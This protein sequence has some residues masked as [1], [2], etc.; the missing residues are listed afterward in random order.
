M[1]SNAYPAQGSN[2]SLISE[3][4]CRGYWKGHEVAVKTILFQDTGGSERGKLD[5]ACKE[6]AIA[7]KLCHPSIVRT[8]THQ[9]QQMKSSLKGELVDFKLYLIQVRL[10]LEG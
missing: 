6:A 3:V 2:T 10:H 8:Y 4:H 7:M 1:A 5:R 9:L